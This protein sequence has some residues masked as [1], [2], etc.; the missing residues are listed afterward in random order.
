MYTTKGVNLKCGTSLS[1]S[2]KEAPTVTFS[3]VPGKFGVCTFTI[4]APKNLHLK[5][6]CDSP[7]ATANGQG[8]TEFR[9]EG[10]VVIK[11]NRTEEQPQV[12]CRAVLEE[13]HVEPIT[14]NDIDIDVSH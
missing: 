1:L 9:G 8:A 14:N 2:E 5:L 13:A 6:T 7:T 11:F 4:E 10:P 12:S 3:N